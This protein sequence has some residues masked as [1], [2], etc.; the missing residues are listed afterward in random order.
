MNWAT[1]QIEQLAAGRA[2][3]FRPRGHSMAPRI[4]DRQLV[5][6]EPDHEPQ[7]DDAVLCTVGTRAYVHLIKAIRGRGARRR[8]L[9]GNNRGGLNGWI[10]RDKIHGVVVA[11]RRGSC[12]G[13]AAS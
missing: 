5:R 7:H 11:V 10:G 9:I 8:Y 12:G 1:S 3:E 6:V 2:V 13:H 4:K